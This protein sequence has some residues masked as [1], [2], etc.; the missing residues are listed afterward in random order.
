[1]LQTLSSSRTSQQ[2]DMADCLGSAHHDHMHTDASIVHEPL[3]VPALRRARSLTSFDTTSAPLPDH[4]PLR[5]LP[6]FR[7]ELDREEAD[8]DHG[9]SSCAH[10]RCKAVCL[11]VERSSRKHL[12]TTTLT[13]DVWLLKLVSLLAVLSSLGT[14]T[15]LVMGSGMP[16]TPLRRTMTTTRLS[17]PSMDLEEMYDMWGVSSA[18][19]AAPVDRPTSAFRRAARSP[20]AEPASATAA[21]KSQ[22]RLFPTETLTASRVWRAPSSVAPDGG[23]TAATTMTQAATLTAAAA[24]AAAPAAAAPAAPAP[25]RLFSGSELVRALDEHGQR[26]TVLVWGAKACR[27]C[28]RVQPQMERLAAK[29][30]AN[31]LFVYHD[32]ATNGLFAEHEVTQTPTVHVYDAAGALFDRAVYSAADLPRFSSVLGGACATA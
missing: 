14:A 30:G 23:R 6:S 22:E 28:R 15:G 17:T 12:S 3:A 32:V 31:F 9:C 24:P 5:R 7:I 10:A 27:T 26:P 11:V 20:R 25:R 1:M 19:Q 16:T 29:A 2:H 4:T 18:S 8:P 13:V 21:R